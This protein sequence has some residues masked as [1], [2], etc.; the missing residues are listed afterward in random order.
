MGKRKKTAFSGDSQ[1]DADD[2]KLPDIGRL[3]K[4]LPRQQLLYQKGSLEQM[5]EAFKNGVCFGQQLQQQ[6][7]ADDN[8]EAMSVFAQYWDLIPDMRKYMIRNGSSE[9]NA[10]Y[11]AQRSLGKQ[12]MDLVKSSRF[13]LDFLRENAS[14][15]TKEALAYCVLVRKINLKNK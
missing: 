3:K 2:Y 14:F 8:V 4:E 13:T 10:A 15:L 12:C 6:M 7:I 9:I 5:K 1:V 11:L